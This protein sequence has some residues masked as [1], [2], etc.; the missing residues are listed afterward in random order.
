MWPWHLHVNRNMAVHSEPLPRLPWNGQEKHGAFH[1]ARCQ[2]KGLAWLENLAQNIWSHT[3]RSSSS[4]HWGVCTWIST[5][6]IRSVHA[7]FSR[8]QKPRSYLNLQPNVITGFKSFELYHISQSQSS[9]YHFSKQ[10]K[11]TN[12]STLPT[13]PAFWKPDV[14]PRI[15][16]RIFPHL[17]CIAPLS[18]VPATL[19]HFCFESLLPATIGPK[20]FY[21]IDYP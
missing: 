18:L 9:W 2:P 17:L 14:C 20:R 13:S 10:V 15:S 5:L 16:H 3:T 1:P 6:G 8:G 7:C 11:M 19:K 4:Y 12:P 21:T